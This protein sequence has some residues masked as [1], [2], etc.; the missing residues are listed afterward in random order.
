MKTIGEICPDAESSKCSEE[1]CKV[2]LE[3]SC[4]VYCGEIIRDHIMEKRRATLK[5]FD[6]IIIDSSEIRVSA[7]ELKH[8]KGRGGVLKGK[9]KAGRIDDVRE[10]FADGLIVLRRMLERMVKPCICIQLVLYTKTEI[11]DRSELV[12]LNRPIHNVPN[13]LRITTAVCGNKLPDKYVSV[14]LL[15]LPS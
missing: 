14:S 5:M 12:E 1:G 9:G 11:K 6:C 4:V 15:K 8:R 3:K 2:S 13:R 10:K 7:V